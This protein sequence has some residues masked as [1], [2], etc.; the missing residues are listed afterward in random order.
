[1]NLGLVACRFLLSTLKQFILYEFNSLVFTFANHLKDSK[2]MKRHFQLIMLGLA[3]LFMGNAT[4]SAALLPNTTANGTAYMTYDRAAWATI[5]PDAYYTDISGNPTGAFGPTSD[6]DG[7]RWIFLQRFEGTSWV[8][9][10][11][12][13]DYLVP[14]PS[15][16]PLLQPLGGFALP[17]NTYGINSFAAGHKITAYNSTTNPGGYIG[18]GGSFRVTSDFNEPGASVWWEHL[19]IVQDQTDLIWRIVAT[20][21]PGQ[22]SIFELTNVNTETVGSHLHLSADYKWGNTD[23]LQ[24]LQDVNGHVDTDAILGHIEIV[25]VPELSSGVMI[26]LPMTLLACVAARRRLLARES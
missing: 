11:Y 22:G 18:L 17:V 5:A 15:N 6:S 12:P 9:A 16:V 3:S 23:W 1:M 25:P 10:H 21:G 4:T 8:N 24:F 20:T 19:A 14:L 7:A 13:S 26:G 2:A